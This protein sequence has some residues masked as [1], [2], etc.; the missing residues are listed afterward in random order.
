MISEN[1]CWKE[2]IFLD[3]QKASKTSLD[4]QCLPHNYKNRKLFPPVKVTDL[5][6][7]TGV[8]LERS[9]ALGHGNHN[10]LQEVTNAALV[11]NV[12]GLVPM[13]ASRT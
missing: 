5:T 2:D 10:A 1:P 8:Y 6:R 13:K 3:E 11:V 7:V 4:L 12:I 9:K